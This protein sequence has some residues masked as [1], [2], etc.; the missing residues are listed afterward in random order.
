ME[1][2][3]VLAAWAEIA[4]AEQ[5]T[6]S[7]LIRKALR[8]KVRERAN[9]PALAPR[10]K[11]LA[12]KMAPSAPAEFRSPAQ[13]ARFKRAQREHDW[14]LLDLQLTEPHAVQSKNSIVP[15]KQSVRVLK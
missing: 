3:V 14:L 15:P 1:N 13:V 9:D 11:N 7:D 12:R 2:S 8:D 6:V 5:T 10:L 4:K